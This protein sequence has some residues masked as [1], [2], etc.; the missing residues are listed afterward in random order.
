LEGFDVKLLALSARGLTN[1]DIQEHLAEL[2]GVEV[3]PT[4]ISTITDAV[5]EEVRT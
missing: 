5:L 3:S 1:R 2:Y 4:L